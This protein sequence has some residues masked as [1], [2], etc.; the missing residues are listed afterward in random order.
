MGSGY[1]AGYWFAVDDCSQ[2]ALNTMCDY[3]N[4]QTGIAID[5]NNSTNNSAQAKSQ[6][7]RER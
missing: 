2:N 7:D 5:I 3:I 4:K 1:H 6:Y